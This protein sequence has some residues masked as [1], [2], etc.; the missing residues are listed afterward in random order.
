MRH[1]D[2]GY[3]FVLLTPCAQGQ[4]DEEN[5]GDKEQG[6]GLCLGQGEFHAAKEEEGRGHHGPCRPTHGQGTVESA[7]T[8]IDRD[9]SDHSD[10]VKAG[11]R[12]ETRRDGKDDYGQRDGN[13]Q[14]DGRYAVRVQAVEATRHLSVARHHEHEA[15]ERGRRR[16][17]RAEEQHGERDADK[18]SEGLSDL[19]PE[20]QPRVV[21]GG[22]TKDIVLSFDDLSLE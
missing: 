6:V 11:Q 20:G 3:T 4:A 2:C 14:R 7:R 16:V 8:E 15:D 17:D 18:P 1:L 9:G 10:G 5:T 19:R 21:L 12:V 13:H 22:E